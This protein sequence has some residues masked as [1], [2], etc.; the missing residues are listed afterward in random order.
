MIIQQVRCG[1]YNF[2]I[3]GVS[4]TSETEGTIVYRVHK[5][6]NIQKFVEKYWQDPDH[7]ERAL[8]PTRFLVYVYIYKF[9]AEN[10][11]SDITKKFELKEILIDSLEPDNKP[12][13]PLDGNFG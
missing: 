6:G 8:T 11:G 2:Y 5:D 1:N 7:Q 13:E 10:Q 4:P 3:T 12:N 9:L